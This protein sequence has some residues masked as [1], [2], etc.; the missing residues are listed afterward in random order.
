MNITYYICNMK[1]LL[2]ILLCLP[3]IGFGQIGGNEVENKENTIYNSIN[4]PLSFKSGLGIDIEDA[5]F[6]FYFIYCIDHYTSITD[7][8]DIYNTISFPI[9]YRFKKEV[10]FYTTLEGESISIRP[11]ALI[12][13]IGYNIGIEYEIIS[14]LQARSGIVIPIYDIAVYKD[15]PLYWPPLSLNSLGFNLEL[16]YLLT[17]NLSSL[18]YVSR[19]NNNLLQGK[20]QVG[21]SWY[22][23]LFIGLKYRL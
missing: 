21:S 5:D 18:L 16:D 19:I 3:M 4:L 22:T 23:E 12:L 15:S 20:Y 8:L 11:P 13:K 2:L 1:K 17:K 7:K 10:P 6:S 9:I 14:S